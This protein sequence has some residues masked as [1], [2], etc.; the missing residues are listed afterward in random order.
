[1]KKSLLPIIALATLLGTTT[2]AWAQANLVHGISAG[3]GLARAAGRNND[4]KSDLPVATTS[5]YRGHSFA[6]LRTPADQLPKKGA[7]EVTEVETQLDRF[8]TAMLADSTSSFCT[9][10]QRKAIQTALVSLGRAQSRWDMQPY[11][12]EATFYLAEDARRQ[13]KALAAPAK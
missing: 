7:A 13:Q 2:Q 12:Q 10:E 9:P 6:M 4:A 3:I 1:M 8:H 5:T 11:Q